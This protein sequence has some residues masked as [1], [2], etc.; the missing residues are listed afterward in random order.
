MLGVY[1]LNKANNLH[2]CRS[3]A[4]KIGTLI[5][6]SLAAMSDAEAI[7]FIIS[8]VLIVSVWKIASDYV[9]T[10][11]WNRIH[12]SNVGISLTSMV[13]SVILDKAFYIA[14]GDNKNSFLDFKSFVPVEEYINQIVFYINTVLQLFGAD[15]PSK[16][17]FNINTAFYFTRTI[18]VLI[19]FIFV[20]YN[21]VLWIKGRSNDYLTVILSTGI[22]LMSIVFVI[23]DIGGD[24]NTGRYIAILPAVLSTIIVRTI[25]N[26]GIRW[27][28]LFGIVYGKGLLLVVC[29]LLLLDRAYPIPSGGIFRL[30]EQENLVEVLKEHN[31]TNG[32]ASFWN[33][34]STTVITNNQIKVRA[35]MGDNFSMHNWFC[36]SEWYTTPANFVVVSKGGYIRSNIRKHSSDSWNT[37]TDY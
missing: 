12:L 10:G 33:A 16:A 35:I 14:G 30:E 23:T 7:L 2:D 20:G 19:A 3:I 22:V 34:S 4:Y 5:I 24:A 25:K 15:F 9:R 27:S 29:M 1:F 37:R 11:K 26:T 31:L 8:S 32:Y 6:F 13:F 17:L 28:E 18:V 36:K 21:I